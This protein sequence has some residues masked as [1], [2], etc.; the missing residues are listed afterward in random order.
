MSATLQ[1]QNEG[2]IQPKDYW[3]VIDTCEGDVWKIQIL[4]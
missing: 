1:G 4:T 2:P 3:S